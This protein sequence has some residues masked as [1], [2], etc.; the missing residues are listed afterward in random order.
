MSQVHRVKYVDA[1]FL[2]SKEVPEV[3]LRDQEAY[4]YVAELDD[5]YVIN[6][7][8]KSGISPD[9]IARSKMDVVKGLIIPK[10]V[11]RVEIDD[12]YIG[13]RIRVH[14]RDVVYVANLPRFQYSVMESVGVVEKIGDEVILLENPITQRISP[15]PAERHP[16]TD[17]P[18]YL[19]IPRSRIEMIKML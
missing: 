5:V 14:W 9:E 1:A 3:R 4:G 7:I 18:T 6:F 2:Y 15:S 17:T 16:K 10:P 11:H 8:K 12:S 13:K 19:L